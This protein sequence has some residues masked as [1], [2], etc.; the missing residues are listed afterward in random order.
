MMGLVGL[1]G[2]IMFNA[3]KLTTDLP[4]A[5]ASH[6]PINIIG[7]SAMDAFFAGNGTDGLS[8]ETAYVLEG[9][10]IDAGGVG[11]AIRF[12]NTSRY[13]L[14]RNCTL[15]G[16]EFTIG[17]AGA[18]FYEVENVFITESTIQYNN[19]IGIYFSES[20]NNEVFQNYIGNNTHGIIFSRSSNLNF[21][22]D[23]VIHSDS[24]NG[25]QFDNSSYNTALDNRIFGAS[26]GISIFNQTMHT[27]L[28]NNLLET[29]QI[30]IDIDVFSNHST[31]YHNTIAQGLNGIVLNSSNH[32]AIENNA[33]SD[34]S[35]FGVILNDVSDSTITGNLIE[36][37]RIGM[38]AFDSSDNFI[39]MNKFA[40]CSYSC[41]LDN[42]VNDW[43]SSKFGNYWGDYEARYPA[44]STDDDRIWNTPYQINTTSVYDHRPMVATGLPSVTTP[45]NRTNVEGGHCSLLY[46][47]IY[48]RTILGPAGHYVITKNGLPWEEGQW[49]DQSMIELVSDYLSP[50][51]HI[52]KLV[53][54]DG[55]RFGEIENTIQMT[56][57]PFGTPVLISETQTINEYSILIEWEIT[58]DSDLYY[59]Y[60]ND[61]F[62]NVVVAPTTEMLV[63]FTEEGVYNIYVVAVNGVLES[64]P[65]NVITITVVEKSIPGY[66]FLIGLSLI[67]LI[68]GVLL[69][70]RKVKYSP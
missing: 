5:S 11:S 43:N 25:I 60:V 7:N 64:D 65:S 24:G 66:S 20:T 52:F 55:T 17:E 13:L 2:F 47:T 67:G 44:A 4:L 32:A 62:Y 57:T 58:P 38:Q 48:D 61:D 37:S 3:E 45:G 16:A 23:N 18:A 49:T 42:G 28:T 22:S 69:V 30:G 51:I 12:Q 27:N 50:G 6:A 31:I 21:V 54:N 56:I 26:Y 10:E 8:Y 36:H 41:A 35:G 68:S 59:L 9:L 70:K 53:A 34:V 63:E 39:Y 46:W 15:T 40:D 1:S 14:I 33:I 19:Y 29:N